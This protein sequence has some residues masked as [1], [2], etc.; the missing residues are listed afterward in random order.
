M[1]SGESFKRR[2]CA[3][4][5]ISSNC[6]SNSF[7]FCFRSRSLN[8]PR[9]SPRTISLSGVVTSLTTDKSQAPA[10]ANAPTIAIGQA[11]NAVITPT[12]DASISARF[13]GWKTDRRT[14]VATGFS[15]IHHPVESRVSAVDRWSIAAW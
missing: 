13:F 14:R 2:A 4:L 7:S 12:I 6:C 11:A 10:A 15:I 9:S 3:A 8:P 1:K 5:V